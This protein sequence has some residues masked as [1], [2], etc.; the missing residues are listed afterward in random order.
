MG[1]V[2]LLQEAWSALKH[3]HKEREVLALGD[4]SSNSIP[5]LDHFGL[6]PAWSEHTFCRLLAF[7]SKLK[8]PRGC[9]VELPMAFRYKMQDFR[10]PEF[11]WWAV[12]YTKLVVKTA[13]LFPMDVYDNYCL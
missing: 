13:A 12:A 7:W 6:V 1:G 3:V 11:G 8:V 2:S 9:I 4:Q 10:D 5:V